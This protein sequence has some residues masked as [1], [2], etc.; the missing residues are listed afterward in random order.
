MIVP[1]ANPAKAD[2]SVSRVAV[3]IE[4]SA[5]APKI[6]M[7]ISLGGARLSLCR[8]VARAQISNATSTASGSASALAELPVTARSP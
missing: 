1:M 5:K 7:M 2:N 6:A 3:R 8:W 4:K